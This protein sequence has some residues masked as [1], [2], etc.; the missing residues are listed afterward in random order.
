MP[1]ARRHLTFLPQAKGATRAVAAA[2]AQA[3]EQKLAT[4]NHTESLELVRCLLRVVS[5]PLEP[6]AAAGP[7]PSLPQHSRTADALYC[8]RPLSMLHLAQSI[9][10]LSYLRGLFPD[11]SFRPV[12]MKNLDGMNIKMLT[13]ACEETKRLIDWVEHGEQREGSSAGSSRWLV[14]ASVAVTSNG[15]GGQTHQPTSHDFTHPSCP[16]YSALVAAAHPPSWVP[17][18]A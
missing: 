17:R 1:A 13:P 14:Q 10:H 18:C 9:Y 4:I 3:Q 7:P 5:P 16:F 11:A 15:S 8:H 2:V 12:E 6:C